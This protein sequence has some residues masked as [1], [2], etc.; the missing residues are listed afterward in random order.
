MGE[1]RP[2]SSLTRRQLLAGGLGVLASAATGGALVQALRQFGR[3]D[4]I[5]GEAPAIRLEADRWVT[6]ADSVSFAVL[7][8]NGSGGR[9]AMAVAE[10]MALS[11][12]GEPFGSVS[13]LGD[14]CYYG[15]ISERFDDVFVKPFTP[16][17]GAG[18]EFELAVGNHDGDVFFEEG[19]PDV[20]ATLRLLG[21][22]GRFYTVTRGP[23]DLFYLDTGRLLKHE[24]DIQLEWLD[25]ALGESTS[26]WRIVC[27]HHPLYSSGN[28]GS[29]D[30]LDD[31]EDVVVDHEVDLVLAGH[32]HHYERTVP[33]RGVTHVVSGGGCKL[34]PVDPSDFTAFA[35]STLQFLRI[36]VHGDRLVGRCIGVEGDEI[37]RFELTPRQ[38][39]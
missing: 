11:Y 36:D 30:D 23:V 4:L 25:Q 10:Q 12:R 32:D 2:A 13:L 14:I 20:E 22:P 24:R 37:D 27:Q 33:I 8:D 19:V 31:L 17:I 21:T 15:P 9:Q 18:V 26:P 16:L 29:T 39:S 34:T 28:H 5:P 38:R 3:E 35:Q 7:G 1:P 6:T